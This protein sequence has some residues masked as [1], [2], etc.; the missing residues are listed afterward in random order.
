MK[1]A[2]GEWC[3]VSFKYEMLGIYCFLCDLLGHSEKYCAKVFDMAEDDGIRYWGPD[4]RADSRRGG[5]TGGSKWLREEPKK[6]GVVNADRVNPVS[7]GY[8][9]PR[10]HGNIHFAANIPTNQLHTTTALACTNLNNDGIIPTDSSRE[11]NAL[12][13]VNP[14]IEEVGND[15]AEEQGERKR[16]RTGV[17]LHG[18][19]MSHMNSDS[20]ADQIDPFGKN[21]N[22]VPF[23]MAGSGSQTCREP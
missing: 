19:V 11:V 2:G 8:G 14:N 5:G 13:R 18:H 3:K 7:G 4:L 1:K 10:N 17:L 15:N 16:S 20:S 23:L 22:V 21:K 12:V 6:Q 9:N